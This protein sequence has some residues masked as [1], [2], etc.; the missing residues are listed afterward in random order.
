M[1]LR[2]EGGNGKSLL[3]SM[4]KKV[5]GKY[6]SNNFCS[7]YLQHTQKDERSTIIWGLKLRRFIAGEEPEKIPFKADA[8]K[9]FA[10]GVI[11][12]RTNYATDNEDINIGCLWIASNFFVQFDSDTEQDS[13][14]RRIRGIDFYYKFVEEKYYD[15][16][17]PRHK[18]Q[19]KNAPE[20]IETE[21]F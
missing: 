7:S 12:A 5:F 11:P 14:R 16:E 8:F 2:G 15:E 18:L 13:L 19:D 4:N 21:E 17:N 20:Y 6:A 9:N 1:F 3:M 10:G